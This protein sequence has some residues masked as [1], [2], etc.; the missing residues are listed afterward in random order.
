MRYCIDGKNSSLAHHVGHEYFRRARVFSPSS[1]GGECNVGVG[2]RTDEQTRV[3]ALFREA[4]SDR[5][6]GKEGAGGE[7]AGGQQTRRRAVESFSL[8]GTLGPW[9]P[10]LYA[11]NRSHDYLTTVS[12]IVMC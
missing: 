11:H 5:T 2:P 1:S 7:R 9:P 3:D 6:D 12:D 10:T 8:V 4:G